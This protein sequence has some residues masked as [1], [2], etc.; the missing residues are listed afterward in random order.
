MNNLIEE[1]VAE[2]DRKIV[3]SLIHVFYFM[4]LAGIVALSFQNGNESVLTIAIVTTI[5]AAIA[6]CLA[7]GLKELYK[8][9]GIVIVLS[10]VFNFIIT[11]EGLQKNK[12]ETSYNNLIYQNK[13]YA[14]TENAKNIKKALENYNAENYK[15]A[16]ETLRKY[17]QNESQDLDR[18][19]N[20]V[21]AIKNITPELIPD[22]KVAM[23]DN[24]VSL[25]EYNL[26]KDQTIKN[27]S[28]KKLTNEQLVLLGSIK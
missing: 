24:F 21:N 9:V 15:V 17:N 3:A 10:L 26:L 8:I 14:N 6:T 28:S 20:L 2:N 12:I 19:M 5:I 22:L 18:V 13:N 27:I 16:L 25:E 4:L 7:N 11:K 23:A 1:D